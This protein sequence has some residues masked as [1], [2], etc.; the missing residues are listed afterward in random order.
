M[1]VIYSLTSSKG[2]CSVI[3]GQRGNL[4]IIDAGIKYDIVNRDKAVNYRLH[5]ADTLLITHSHDDH[6][7]Y[8]DEFLSR[9][10]RGCTVGCREINDIDIKYREFLKIINHEQT[11]KTDGFV[12]MPLDM[13]HTN[14]DGTICSCFGYLIGDRFSK[15]KML[16]ATDTQYIMYQFPPLEYYCLECNF[17]EEEER[18]DEKSIEERRVQS[19][20]SYESVVKF[21]KMQELSKCKEI[22][23]LHLSSTIKHSANEI[24]KMLCTD[25]EMELNVYV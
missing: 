10:T 17:F 24:K 20:M 8:I 25:L 14:H 3:E 23:L 2:N 12:L 19:H 16:W 18:Q 4:L 9:V 21:L 6:I 1:K 15:E 22:R 5:N 13:V 7:K 11:T